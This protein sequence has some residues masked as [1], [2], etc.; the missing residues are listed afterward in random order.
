MISETVLLPVEKA[1]F[2]VESDIS[3]WVWVG[4]STARVGKGEACFEEENND[5]NRFSLL[6]L[7]DVGPKVK[8]GAEG[9]AEAPEVGWGDTAAGEGREVV[10]IGA[11]IGVFGVV[12]DG[13]LFRLVGIS[14]VKAFR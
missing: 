9:V 6:P 10:L 2:S 5:L 14:A 13:A 12:L 11:F 3:D 8:G 4:P 1:G 7:V